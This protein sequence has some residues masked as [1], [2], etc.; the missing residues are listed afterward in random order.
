MKIV[1]RMFLKIKVRGNKIFSIVSIFAILANSFAPV[2]AAIPTYTYAEG[3]TAPVEALTKE[4]KEE[5]KVEE[6]VG[7]ESVL[8]EEK[9]H[10]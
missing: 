6:K 5:I 2:L 10:T 3:I 1:N 8:K 7:S 9:K 4:D